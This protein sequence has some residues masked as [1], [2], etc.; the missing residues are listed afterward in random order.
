MKVDANTLKRML[1]PMPSLE[2][3]VT[4]PEMS[5][6][7]YHYHPLNSNFGMNATAIGG[8]GSGSGYYHRVNGSSGGR[9]SGGALSEPETTLSRHRL[10][11]IPG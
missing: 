7:R 1:K 11:R 9:D 2:S 6:R 5:K 8:I 4:S 3:P 10:A